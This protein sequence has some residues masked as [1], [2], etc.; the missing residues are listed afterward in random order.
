MLRKTQ[1]EV[2]PVDLT[3][4]DFYAKLELDHGQHTSHPFRF[5][6]LPG[7]EPLSGSSAIGSTS[8]AR[9][10]Q[11][12]ETNFGATTSA[13]LQYLQADR[14][15]DVE[16]RDDAFEHLMAIMLTATAKL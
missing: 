12:L 3:R 2:M 15:G 13:R 4:F 9:S 7:L 10:S 11:A 5:N 8:V 14:D 6:N 1:E 16:T